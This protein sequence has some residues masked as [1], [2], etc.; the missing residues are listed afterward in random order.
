M[1]SFYD[2]IKIK[3]TFDFL[4]ILKTGKQLTN[5][6]PK[7]RI[8][9]AALQLF[10]RQ[11]FAG[12]GLRELAARAEVNLAMINYFFG[13]KKALFKEIMDNFFEGYLAIAKKELSGE[14]TLSVKL[15]R[16]IDSS[17]HYFDFDQDSLLVTIT[18]L[19]H[20][21]P[22]IISYKA[23]WVRQIAEVLEKEICVPLA[24]ET[25]RNIPSTCMGPMLTS[26]MASRFLFS[27]VMNQVTK[28]TGNAVD[29]ATYT[30]MITNVFVQG[31]TDPN[32]K[33]NSN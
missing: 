3:Q 17:V 22:E 21:D 33:H 23:N 8:F 6:P 5:S 25:G 2:A 11:G 12:T 19:P 32:W 15:R 30:E 10:A 26:L 29:I 9:Q 27:P 28:E 20:D 7:E 14:D 13:S 1:E 18:E 16:F 31:I 4:I 24:K